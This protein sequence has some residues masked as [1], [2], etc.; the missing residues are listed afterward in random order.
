[1]IRRRDAQDEETSGNAA[2]RGLD[3]ASVQRSGDGLEI[4]E[5]VGSGET[6][7][8]ADRVDEAD[9]SGNDRGTKNLGGDG[10]EGRQID[11]SSSR[12]DREGQQHRHR[13]R[14]R[15]QEQESSGG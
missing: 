8:A 4:A 3:Q 13:M 10:P 12:H 9:R 11:G 6:S 7:N 5:G 15:R 14:A 1:M 2:E